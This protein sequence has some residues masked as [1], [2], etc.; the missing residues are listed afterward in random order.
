MGEIVNVYRILAGKAGREPFGKLRQRCKICCS[1]LSG[2]IL[3]NPPKITLYMT[4][5]VN[6]IAPGFKE[7]VG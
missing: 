7:L 6:F 1:V 4:V 2:A 5:K 3:K